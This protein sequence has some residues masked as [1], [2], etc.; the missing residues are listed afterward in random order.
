MTQAT[1]NVPNI[2]CG[3][4]V[5]AIESELSEAE[6][7]TSVTAD[8]ATKTVTVQWDAPAS[9]EGVR[10]ILSEINYPAES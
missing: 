3:H 7:V 4:C 5:S 6:G 10:A 9:I 1:L 2:S 8:A